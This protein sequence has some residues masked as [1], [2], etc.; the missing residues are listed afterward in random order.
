MDLSW[1]NWNYL[2]LVIALFGIIGALFNLIR[3]IYRATSRY[4]A[5]GIL[6]LVLV[7]ASPSIASAIATID[8]T[9][10]NANLNVNDTA[11]K[12]T[13]VDQTVVDILKALNLAP[14]ASDP[15]SVQTA[16][17]LSHSVIA[18]AVY[19]VGFL[20]TEILLGPLLGL[21]IY[22]LSFCFFIPKE[23]RKHKKHRG[24]TFLVSLICS[25]VIG[26]LFIAP[27]SSVA[28]SLT[29]VAKKA[30]ENESLS[31]SEYGE[32]IKLLASYNDSAFYSAMTFGSKNPDKAMD[33]GIMKTATRVTVNGATTGLYQLIIDVYPILSSVVPSLE[34]TDGQVKIDYARLLEK[35]TIKTVLTSLSQWKLLSELLP[36]L[37]SIGLQQAKINVADLDVDFSAIDWSSTFTSVEEIYDALY[38]P[39]VRKYVAPALQNGSSTLTIGFDYNDKEAYKKGLN[40]LGDFLSGTTDEN[41]NKTP[42]TLMDKLVY[43]LLANYAKTINAKEGAAVLSTDPDD[44]RKLDFHPIFDGLADAVFSLMQ[45]FKITAFGGDEFTSLGQKVMD[46]AK[47]DPD[48]FVSL[49]KPLVIGGNVR[50][51]VNGVEQEETVSGLLSVIDAAESV[52]DIRS[53]LLLLQS[54][55][56]EVGKYLSGEVIDELSTDIENNTLDLKKEIGY[57]INAVADIEAIPVKED[58]SLDVF[59]EKGKTQVRKVLEDLK[60]SVLITK[61]G[62]IVA[63]SAVSNLNIDLSK[64]GLKLSDFD[65]N[66]KD[67]SGNSILISELEKAADLLPDIGDLSEKM[68]NLDTSDVSGV[69]KALD[70]ETTGKVNRIVRAIAD[71][72]IINPELTSEQKKNHTEDNLTKVMVSV[73]NSKNVQDLGFDFSSAKDIHWVD[74]TDPENDELSSLISLIDYLHTQEEESGVISE[75][76]KGN[77]SVD[78]L[79][80]K[81]LISGLF[82]KLG[83]DKLIGSQ[84]SGFLDKKIAP[85]LHDSLG[86]DVTFSNVKDWADEG[87]KIEGVAQVL[88]DSNL[89]FNNIDLDSLDET[90][91]NQLLTELSETSF[92]GV[93][94]DKNG[95]YVDKF[96]QTVYSLLKKA[97]LPESI[98][99]NLSEEDFSIVKDKLTGETRSDFKWVGTK[100]STTTEDGVTVDQDTD[101]EIATLSKLIGE[102]KGLDLSVINSDNINKVREVADTLLDSKILNRIIIPVLDNSL[103]SMNEITIPGTEGEKSQKLDLTKI[104]VPY[105][106]RMT[107]EEK[108]STIDSF[109]SLY[110]DLTK[111]DENGQTVLDS[112]SSMSSGQIKDAL[113]TELQNLLTKMHQNKLMSTIR[114]GKDSSFF[115]E[116]V[117][118]FIHLI[119]FDKKNFPSAS[120]PKAAN[121]SY[122]NS[123]TDFE[124][125]YDG[126]GKVTEVGEI[127]RFTAILK[128]I[129]SKGLT[130]DSFT[131][132]DASSLDGS[133]VS[134][135]LEDINESELL[136]PALGDLFNTV[137]ANTGIND[138]V[139][140]RSINTYVHLAYSKENVSWWS[141]EITYLGTFFT[142]VKDIAGGTSLDLGNLDL[143]SS[144]EGTL[145]KLMQPIDH[146]ELFKDV[147]SCLIL[148]FLDNSNGSSDTK[149]SDYL[150]DLELTNGYLTNSEKANRIQS[151]LFYDGHTD[152]TLK[153]QCDLLQGFISSA[154]KLTTSDFSSETG[155]K[156]LSGTIFNL[157][158][159]T[160]EI[161]EGTEEGSYKAVKCGLASEML[162]NLLTEKLV[163]QVEDASEKNDVSSKLKA[164]FFARNT[165]EGDYR[166]VNLLE[167]RGLEGILSLADMKLPT[168]KTSAT[169]DA[170]VAAFRNQ[171]IDAF[172]LMG[173]KNPASV[174]AYTDETALQDVKGDKITYLKDGEK[175]KEYNYLL[176]Q[177]ETDYVNENGSANSVLASELFKTFGNKGEVYSNGTDSYT[178]FQCIDRYNA[179]VSNETSRKTVN[180]VL[181]GMTT[182]SPVPGI[183]LTEEQ[184]N[185][186]KEALKTIFNDGDRITVNADDEIRYETESFEET[187]TKALRAILFLQFAD[188]NGINV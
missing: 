29:P 25:S 67:A 39:I 125:A 55:N 123:I 97:N 15:T 114:D 146:M 28:S 134:E 81:G 167:A 88:K 12:V 164:L 13:T 188:S 144:G 87:T 5:I 160:Q 91:V 47:K 155:L 131:S 77:V 112:F 30:E 141:N 92:L 17:A 24:I 150:R 157:M 1:F 49:V 10:L 109:F 154:V 57:L 169:Y 159:S 118:D 4:V 130:L 9:S 180:T 3:G 85:E 23:K 44:Y 90:T 43:P 152:Q 76:I 89:D 51:T 108:K 185:A 165:D 183:G 153:T 176:K 58:K 116:V 168:D 128:T 121:L 36:T 158:M 33:N 34:V 132:F 79:A 156:S 86:V 124:D 103:S 40:A 64:F 99:S 16:L 145:D 140:P 27:F 50:L 139:A 48:K 83:N 52:L 127:K 11:V 137:I 41:G 122:I 84:L 143:T 53:L 100:K 135:I 105:L 151:I 37:A 181:T 18:L 172:T 149:L 119:G 148:N 68:K 126:E 107:A 66:P 166:G 46:L 82:E 184:A 26:A 69:I 74:A 138:R 70:T 178:I 31:K 32:Y 75:L 142:N 8:L 95:E 22:A 171:F 20:L 173:R 7:L 117:N 19:I 60:D 104:N 162:A 6:I 35:N 101:G 42:S 62:P 110:D 45:Y 111:K 106:S 187:G 133:L 186:N 61:Y 96:G 72:K 177:Y 174:T 147:K 175:V 161:K 182:A 170:D 59:T 115:G 120:D 102:V 163:G 63:E 56:A 14:T 78:T 65:F 80:T 21:L 129:S 113:V 93:Q 73:L 54:K 136:H 98:S 38:E 2:F 71:N 94:T 179:L